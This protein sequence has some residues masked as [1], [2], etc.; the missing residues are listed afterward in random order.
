MSTHLFTKSLKH[1][2][3][4]AAGILCFISALIYLLILLSY[5]L[6]DPGWTYIT[7]NKQTIANLGGYFGANLA[8]MS[9]TMFG[10]MAYVLP[11]LLG[12]ASWIYFNKSVFNKSTEIAEGGFSLVRCLG[13]VA[14]L[15]AGSALAEFQFTQFN[16]FMPL[17]SGGMLGHFVANLL[18]SYFAFTVSTLLL[19]GMFLIGISL[20]IHLSWLSVADILG[21]LIIQLVTYL[22]TYVRRYGGFMLNTLL[23][24]GALLRQ[25]N[26]RQNNNQNNNVLNT[27]VLNTKRSRLSMDRFMEGGMK[28][29]VEASVENSVKNVAEDE[30]PVEDLAENSVD[31]SPILKAASRA[32]QDDHIPMLTSEPGRQ[33]RVESSVPSKTIN[34]E[35]SPPPLPALGLLKQMHKS[36]G[37]GYDPE[38]L[39]ILSAI[40]E[41]K[42]ADFGVKAEVVEVN[43]GPVITRFEIQPAPGIKVIKISNLAKDL[44]RSLTV[45][46]VRIVEVIPGKSVVGIEIPNEHREIVLLGNVLTTEV[47]QQAPSPVT[48]ALGVNTEGQTVISDLAKMPHLLVAGTTGSGK[49]VGVNT[50]LLSILYKST[51]KEV[52]LIMVDPK[53]LELSVYNGIPHLLTPVVTDMKQAANALRW[54]VIEMDRRYH[55]MSKLG[56]RNLNGYNEKI[57]AARAKN[58]TIPDP[59]WQINKMLDEAQSPP[60]LDTLPYIVVVVDEFAEMMMIVGKKVEELI[61]RLAQ[62]ARAAGIHLI[63][64]TQRPSVDV[65][66]GLIKANIPTRIAFQVSSRIDSRT[67]LDQGGADQLLGNGD[68]LYLPPGSG[69]P[70]RVHGTF[71]SD[72]E[73]HSVVSHWQQQASPEDFSAEYQKMILQTETEDSADIDGN[74]NQGLIHDSEQDPLYDQIVEFVVQSRK[75]SISAVQR[76]FKIGYNR[77]ARIV[78]TL[79]KNGVLSAAENGKR[80]VLVPPSDEA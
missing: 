34:A 9:F 47:Y 71:V 41:Q 61:A 4:E 37:R 73:V 11:L 79:E 33:I 13:V 69:L 63:L 46:S 39:K 51:P 25:S 42:L 75:S 32:T 55:L 26:I 74:E 58:E 76:R 24:K 35:Y 1:R 12:Y 52:R 30:Y 20:T 27:K 15:L 38:K 64:A 65:I 68:M 40:L 17:S 60:A 29:G 23:A 57:L 7:N 28:G 72:E 56:V 50:M 36:M 14:I 3:Y 18:V 49:S 10:I 53:M 22:N 31:P 80:E 43:P 59:S 8:D 21:N 62:K 77:S 19:L 2:V 70:I 67:V 45:S 6:N 48:L 78:E 5:D 66:T 54:C 16:V 44:A